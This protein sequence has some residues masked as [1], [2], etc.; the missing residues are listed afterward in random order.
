MHMTTNSSDRADCVVIGAGVV[1]L[2]VAAELARRGRDVIV[3]EQEAQFGSGIS[4]RNSEV[5]HAGIYYPPGSLKATLCVEGR[6][7]L[8]RY[9]ESRG[10]PFERCGKLIVAT[11]DDQT[12][13]LAA[14]KTRALNNGV[15]DLQ[16]LTAAEVH[17]LEPALSTVGALWSPSTGIIDSHALMASLTGDVEASGG[18]LVYRTPVESLSPSAGGVTVCTGGDDAYRLDAS[19]VVNAAGLGAVPLML[20]LHA[21]DAAPDTQPVT[22]RVRQRVRQRVSQV[23]AKGHY[24]S[25]VGPAPVSRLVYPIPEPGGLGVHVTLDLNHT[26]RFGPDVQWVDQIDYAID[27]RRADTFYAAIRRYWPGLEAGALVPDYAGIR[28]KLA[29][30]NT[31]HD[32]FLIQDATDHGVP[33]LLHLAGIESPGLTA[34]LAIARLVAN[35]LC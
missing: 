3:L 4:S 23:L 21:A 25:L 1:G 22:K 11:S 29:M 6:Q 28:P 31:L 8:Y 5:I 18:C 17:D 16:T 19:L 27:D 7:R 15:T 20:G 14:I 26:V 24:F 2:A 33:G 10:I 34:C 32:D 30:G 12:A 35:R 13:R 9:C